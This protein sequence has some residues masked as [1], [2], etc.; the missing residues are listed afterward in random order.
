MFWIPAVLWDPE[1][2]L[3]HLDSTEELCACYLWV[4]AASLATLSSP[5]SDLYRR[6]H[7]EDKWRRL[8][9]GAT[10]C[11]LNCWLT[12]AGGQPPGFLSDSRETTLS[13]PSSSFWHN[14]CDSHFLQ[15]CLN[16]SWEEAA[17]RRSWVSFTVR[18]TMTPSIVTQG[19]AIHWMPLKLTIH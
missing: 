4:A 15:S 16:L 12:S 5:Y 3:S 9:A 11:S 13:Q 19:R 17:G 2:S 18:P 7:S 6:D 14:I 1:E 10:R 8:D